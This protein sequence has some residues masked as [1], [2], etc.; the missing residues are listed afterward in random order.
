LW[1]LLNTAA[2]G[3]V[4]LAWKAITEDDWGEEYGGYY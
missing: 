2:M 4:Y 3:M 1:S